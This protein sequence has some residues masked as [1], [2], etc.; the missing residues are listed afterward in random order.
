MACLF[1]R[2]CLS[3][4]GFE[5]YVYA[6]SLWFIACSCIVCCLCLIVLCVGVCVLIVIL[7]V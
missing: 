6:F 5:Y 2:L 3:V 1:V 7:C 4:C